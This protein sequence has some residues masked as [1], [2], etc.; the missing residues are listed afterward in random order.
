MK[1]IILLATICLASCETPN[2]IEERKERE[3]YVKY[4]QEECASNLR[5]PDNKRHT[6]WMCECRS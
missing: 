6:V 2:Q 5:L 3:M 4:C 1:I